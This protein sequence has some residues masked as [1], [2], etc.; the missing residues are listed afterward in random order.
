MSDDTSSSSSGADSPASFASP[1]ARDSRWDRPAPND[2]RQDTAAHHD[3]VAAPRP[4]GGGGLL[5]ALGLLL[6]TVA[7]GALA[8]T[9]GRVARSAQSLSEGSWTVLPVA[10]ARPDPAHAGK[11]VH[12]A[13]PVSG[14][15]PR[16]AELGVAA[17]PGT[18]R[19][20]R[21]VEMFQW[22]EEER[23]D[24]QTRPGGSSTTTTTWTYSRHWAPG[25][26]AS[27][28]F[29]TR[30]GHQNPQPRLASQDWF[31]EGARL[32]GFAL[33][34]AQLHELSATEPLRPDGAEWRYLGDATFPRVGDLRV[35]WR[36]ARPAALS[37]IAA[38]EGE[39]F[40]PFST[41]SGERLFMLA[42]GEREPVEMFGRAAAAD[43]RTAWI[44]RAGVGAAIL[45]GAGLILLGFRRQRA[46]KAWRARTA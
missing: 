46:V 13:G 20:H 12:V 45:L 3:D 37:V 2:H 18:L 30:D 35:G 41:R 26:H 11:L 29:H 9:E 19:L 40:A 42:A 39:G 38:Q 36:V 17:P 34:D 22:R 7:G 33:T 6:V 32:G 10:A 23:R 14:T 24:T 21:V 27:E 31:A 5:L 8:W 4:P 16:D 28:R 44:A 1:V 43:R 25:R 15:P